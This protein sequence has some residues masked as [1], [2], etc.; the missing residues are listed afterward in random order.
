M[1]EQQKF[2]LVWSPTG[3]RP[4]HYRHASHQAAVN[5]AER[6]AATHPGQEFI[7]LGAEALR[8]VDSMKRVEF[9]DPGEE[10]PF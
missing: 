4:P 6:L 3:A 5:E 10:L 1:N 7:V 9:V 8:L 2:W